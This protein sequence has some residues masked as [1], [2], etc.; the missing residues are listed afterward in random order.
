[1]DKFMKQTLSIMM[2]WML[3]NL[4]YGA[5]PG[6]I[7][8]QPSEEGIL[9]KLHENHYILTLKAP[10][11]YIYYFVAQPPK[12]SGMIKTYEFLTLWAKKR[13]QT[14]LKNTLPYATLSFITQKGL[15]VNALVIVAN[16]SYTQQNLN[17]QITLMSKK[18][19]DTGKMH[20]VVLIFNDIL[21]DPSQDLS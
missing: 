21:W 10:P 18:P 2:V 13:F 7:F 1:M 15:H 5:Q 12:H 9:K 20:H 17:Y 8:F 4:S 16:P 6:V 11:S 19:L 3:L 14:C